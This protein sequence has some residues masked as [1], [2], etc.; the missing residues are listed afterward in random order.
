MLKILENNI[1]SL[2]DAF[3]PVI[4]P[5]NPEKECEKSPKDAIISDFDLFINIVLDNLQD[6]NRFVSI[7]KDNKAV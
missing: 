2:K 6:M 4:N 1:Y 7:L 5:L 3:G